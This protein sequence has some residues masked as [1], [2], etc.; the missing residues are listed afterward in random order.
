MGAGDDFP[1]AGAAWDS[2]VELIP[3]RLWPKPTLRAVFASNTIVL[4]ITRA[5]YTPRKE[6]SPTQALARL[7]IRTWRNPVYC[8]Q[9]RCWPVL[10]FNI[11]Y[12]KV[13]PVFPRRASELGV[14][15]RVLPFRFSAPDDSIFHYPNEIT[16]QILTI[17]VYPYSWHVSFMKAGLQLES[18]LLLATTAASHFTKGGLLARTVRGTAH[19]FTCICVFF[20]PTSQQGTIPEAR[21]SFLSHVSPVGYHCPGHMGDNQFS[22]GGAR[23]KLI[24]RVST[25]HH[26]TLSIQHS[27]SCHPPYLFL[28]PISGLGECR[29]AA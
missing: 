2:T 9:Q 26:P 7:R 20:S 15:L 5:D 8:V 16:S 22:S 13:S 1:R 18:P 25:A 19:K 28:V 11:Q 6:S 27:R 17:C 14:R 21:P 3:L 23:T 29:I 4:V 10:I 12:G 24:A